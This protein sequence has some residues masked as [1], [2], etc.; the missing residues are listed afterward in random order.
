VDAPTHRSLFFAVAVGWFAVDQ[1]TKTW[2]LNALDGPPVQV[3]WTLQ[4]TLAFN[5]GASFSMGAGLGPW[6]ALG[7]ALVVGAL[8]WTARSVRSR[9][10]AVALGMIVGGASGNLCDRLLRGDAGLLHGSVVDFIDF[11]WWP[12]F[13]VADIGVVCGAIL[14][15]IATFRGSEQ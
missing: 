1:L 4:F 2:A 13:N 10:M 11:Q 5:S 7:A 6:I 14:L 12:V 3:L 9:L 15:V 8:V